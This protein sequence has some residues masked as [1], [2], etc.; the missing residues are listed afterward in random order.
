MGQTGQLQHDANGGW[1]RYP[2][3]RRNKW[4]AYTHLQ[5]LARWP[6]ELSITSDDLGLVI[7]Q[8]HVT[9][10]RTA[11]LQR[12]ETNVPVSSVRGWVVLEGQNWNEESPGPIECG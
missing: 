11:D 7:L 4:K 2:V 10:I 8:V 9:I 1:E 6:G 5:S 12:C 3:V